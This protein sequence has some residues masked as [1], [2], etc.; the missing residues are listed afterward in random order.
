MSRVPLPPST[1]MLRALVPN[2][3]P[4]MMEESTPRNS[5]MSSSHLLCNDE[6]PEKGR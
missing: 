2:P 4:N 3:I 1:G 6:E 5:E